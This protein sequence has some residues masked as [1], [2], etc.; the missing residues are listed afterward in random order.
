L[1]VKDEYFLTSWFT[2]NFLISFACPKE[3]KAYALPFSNDT[4]EAFINTFEIKYFVNK[5]VR[6]ARV[7][8]TFD[9]FFTL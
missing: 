9:S 7:K 2:D 4:C 6:E 3:G 1:G 5:K 8:A